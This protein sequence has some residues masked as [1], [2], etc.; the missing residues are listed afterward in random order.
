MTVSTSQVTWPNPASTDNFDT[1]PDV[2]CMPS[3]NSMF[4]VG[5]TTPVTCTATD[6]AGNQVTCTFSVTVGKNDY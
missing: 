1:Q 5:M 6:N 3:S 4:T 2:S